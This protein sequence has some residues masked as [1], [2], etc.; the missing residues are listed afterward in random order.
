MEAIVATIFGKYILPHTPGEETSLRR[1]REKV[2][3]A[4][5]YR[6]PRLDEH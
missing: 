2:T 6:E 4:N 5:Y 3:S 1:K